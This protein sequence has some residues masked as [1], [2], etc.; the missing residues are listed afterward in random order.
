MV[1]PVSRAVVVGV[2][3]REGE[4]MLSGVEKA[5]TPAGRIGEGFRRGCRGPR[6]VSTTIILQ[7]IPLS[8]T[9]SLSLIFSLFLT[10]VVLFRSST[11]HSTTYTTLYRQLTRAQACFWIFLTVWGFTK[12]RVTII[13]FRK[14]G[15]KGLKNED[16][17]GQ[18][19]IQKGGQS[20]TEEFRK[21][22]KVG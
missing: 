1:M 21:E 9:S 15:Q 2:R 8:N 3:G 22:D 5:K 17:V 18:K 12:S 4:G 14:V 13:N 7:F 11:Q 16:K 19:F 6:A 10:L 20:T